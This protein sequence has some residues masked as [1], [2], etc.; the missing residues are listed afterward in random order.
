MSLRE[1]DRLAYLEALGV[2]V[3]A[4]PAMI[5]QATAR[6]AAGCALHLGAVS[7]AILAVCANGEEAAMPLAS[8]ISRALREAPAWAWPQ[9]A[10]DGRDLP[11]ACAEHGFIGV[12]LFGMDVARETA[13]E[14]VPSSMHQA[15]VLVAP[16]MRELA[17][18]A[19]ARRRLWNELRQQDLAKKP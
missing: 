3:W 15:P 4:R 8:D 11:A 17:G 10:A 19:A 6:P 9:E 13:G 14:P 1:D 7:S 2:R 5:P 18:S 16:S 12:I